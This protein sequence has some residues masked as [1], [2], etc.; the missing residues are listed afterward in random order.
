MLNKKT[1][2]QSQIYL[3]CFPKPAEENFVGKVEMTCPASLSQLQET[4]L[5]KSNLPALHPQPNCKK[6]CWQSRT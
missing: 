2:W 5:A 6:L 3:P 1:R 4:L